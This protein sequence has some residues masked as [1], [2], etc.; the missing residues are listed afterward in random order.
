MTVAPGWTLIV[1][2]TLPTSLFSGISTSDGA[3]Q[4]VRGGREVRGQGRTEGPLSLKK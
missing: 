1:A 3:G 2:T 4:A